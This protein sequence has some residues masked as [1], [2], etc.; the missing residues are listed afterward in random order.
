VNVRLACVRAIAR[1]Q[2]R[3]AIREGVATALLRE[4]SP[5]VTAALIS[6]VVDARDRT[7]IETLRHLSEDPSRD[8][9]MRDTAAEGLERLLNEGQL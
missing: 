8:A 4:Q 2:E 6:Y 9:A 7:A 3:P 1:F 5:L